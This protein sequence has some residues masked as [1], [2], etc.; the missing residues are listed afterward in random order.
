M[1]AL[2]A[3]PIHIRSRY[4]MASHD[5]ISETTE[6][7]EKTGQVH[8]RSLHSS[9]HEASHLADS[10]GDQFVTDLYKP[11]PPD[12]S[13][14]FE[15]QPLT[16]RAILVGWCLGA[17]VNASNVYLGLKIGSTF[18]ATMF[19]VLIGYALFKLTVRLYFIPVIGAVFGPKEHCLIQ[20]IAT[21]S[22]G[23]SIPFIATV[24]ALFRLELMTESVQSYYWHFAT[25]TAACGLF[26]SA[27]AV[28]YRRPFVIDLARDLE[29]VYPSATACAQAIRTLHVGKTN[30]A[31]RKQ[32][33]ILGLAFLASLVWVVVKQYAPGI[34]STW[35]T[36]WWFYVWSGYK[37]V[38]V[39]VL[40]W[41]FF[42]FEWSPVYIGYG[43]M[44]DLNATGSML[45]GYILAYGFIGPI[46]VHRGIAVGKPYSKEHPELMSFGGL[47]K[48]LVHAPSPKYW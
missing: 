46:L 37:G 32:F 43:M 5:R 3:Y 29:L 2:S 36:F 21:A 28:I 35:Y 7:D 11:F 41:G 26:G 27:I 44:I 14:P 17:V 13:L 19:A 34:L 8:T 1:F 16:I 6:R 30:A 18:D 45:L 48:D 42:I 20:S 22:G 9:D 4:E 15:K 23:M 47:G 10:E 24:P 40:N 31:N 12:P 38:A 33:K 25:L 39:D